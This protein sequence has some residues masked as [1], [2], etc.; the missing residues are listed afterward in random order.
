MYQIPLGFVEVGA[1]GAVVHQV[2]G[3]VFV[4]YKTFLAEG[5]S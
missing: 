2:V 4:G 5:V 3:A 1:I